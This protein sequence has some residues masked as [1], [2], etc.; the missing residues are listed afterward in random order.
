MDR[1][2]GQIGTKFTLADKLE[3]IT[4]IP[5]SVLRFQ[6][7]VAELSVAERMSWASR[8]RTTRVEDE[9]YCLFGLFGVNM[10]TL[11][12]E[13]ENA[14]YRLQE[15][16]ARTHTDLSLFAWGSPMSVNSRSDLDR[17]FK[18]LETVSF[19]PNTKFQ[20]LFSRSPQGMFRTKS[21]RVG[22][23]I[24]VIRDYKVSP[25]ITAE[26]SLLDLCNK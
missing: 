22:E 13:G 11:Y 15:E 4:S 20:Y 23:R 8:R 7:D 14:F 16:I 6:Q 18:D 24:Q 19:Q 21:A 17:Y 5:A 3:K 10:Q 1:G 12:G 25:S 26:V 9:A 2:W